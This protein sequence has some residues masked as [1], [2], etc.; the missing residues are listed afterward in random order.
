MR[1][2][3]VLC[4]LCFMIPLLSFAEDNPPNLEPL[5]D[6]PPPPAGANLESPDE[7]EITIV[8]KGEDTIEEYR[9][10]GELYMMKVTPSHG[11]P[12]YLTKDDPNSSW[13]NSG[14]NPPLIVPRW[15]IFRF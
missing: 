5:P 2:L 4:L 3:K 11:K 14:P 12:Y 15:V 7:P 6:I 10:N 9:I 1:F 13:T 8:K